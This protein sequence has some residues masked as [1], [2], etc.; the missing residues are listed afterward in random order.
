M[1]DCE[2]SSTVSTERMAQIMSDYYDSQNHLKE[3]T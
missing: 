1:C 3:A 2:D